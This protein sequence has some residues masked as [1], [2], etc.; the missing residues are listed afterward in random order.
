MKD[1][2]KSG[3]ENGKEGGRWEKDVCL[4]VVGDRGGRGRALWDLAKEVEGERE[5]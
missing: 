2:Q 4:Y 3:K 5:G 1:S